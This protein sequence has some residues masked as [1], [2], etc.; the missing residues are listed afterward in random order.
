MNCKVERCKLEMFCIFCNGT[1]RHHLTESGLFVYECQ[2]VCGKNEVCKLNF[3]RMVYIPY[4]LVRTITIRIHG[5]TDSTD[6]L[7]IHFTRAFFCSLFF[8][9]FLMFDYSFFP[10]FSHTFHLILFVHLDFTIFYYYVIG[11]VIQG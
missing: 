4:G 9:S 5:V 7:S 3:F 1:I 2:Y 6:F 10:L 8:I 11:I